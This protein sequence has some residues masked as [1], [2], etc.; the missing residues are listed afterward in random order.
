MKRLMTMAA[1]ALLLGPGPARGAE[2]EWAVTPYLWGSDIAVDAAL[3][4]QQ[5]AGGDLDFSDLLDKLDFAFQLHLEGRKGRAGLFG[6]F[7]YLSAG[8]SETVPANPPLP[9]GTEVETDSETMLFEVAGTFRPI[10]E[11]VP[12]ELI[13]G[14]RA[15]SLDLSLDIMLPS[16]LDVTLSGDAGDTLYDVFVGA[17]YYAPLGEN[18]M[19]SIR[20]DVASGDTDFSWNVQGVLGWM[21]GARDQ[22]GLLVG[23]RHMEMELESS[24][25]GLDVEVTQTMTGPMAGFMFRF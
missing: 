10:S 23:Y 18:F 6:D 13:G 19:F 16:P 11:D 8:D 17:R 12:F 14:L 3:D 22:F 20:G 2:W 25:D 1:M 24:L 5:I 21:F 7:T 9:G 4:G 15:I